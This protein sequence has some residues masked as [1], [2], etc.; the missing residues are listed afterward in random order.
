MAEQEDCCSFPWVALVMVAEAAAV[1]AVD[2][3]ALEGA[4]LAAAAQEVIGKIQL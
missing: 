1:A 4:V 2:L 3:E